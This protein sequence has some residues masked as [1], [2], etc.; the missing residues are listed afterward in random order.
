MLP[1]K[2][3]TLATIAML[4][5]APVMAQVP[6]SSPAPAPAE[7][8]AG[9][10]GGGPMW[11]H[12]PG[13][14]GP[15]E[16]AAFARKFCLNRFAM[17]TGELA[18]LEARLELTGRQQPLWDGWYK[19]VIAGVQNQR[20]QCEANIPTN[21]K[22]PTILDRDEHIQ[23]ALAAREQTLKLA[24]PALVALYQSLNPEQREVMDHL[25]QFL[26]HGGRFH[27]H[28][29]PFGEHGGHPFPR[30]GFPGGDPM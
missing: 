2:I 30:P 17:R 5:A 26:H 7:R 6:D 11:H 14:P 16:F 23:A 12:G 4:S 9:G 3:A 25:P 29:G 15:K 28:G 20:K 27:G 1:L 8:P 18:F 13:M 22:P 10:P 21:G 19:I 24:R